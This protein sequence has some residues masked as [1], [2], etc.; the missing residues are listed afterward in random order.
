MKHKKHTSEEAEKRTNEKTELFVTNYDLIKMLRKRSINKRGRGKD[1]FAEEH[2]ID[3][4][5]IE[6]KDAVGLHEVK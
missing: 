2:Q 6:F 3:D 5:D 4:R 1:V